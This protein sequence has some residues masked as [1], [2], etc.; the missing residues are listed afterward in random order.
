MAEHENLKSESNG[1]GGTREGSG[2]RKGGM[3]EATKERLAIKAEFQHRVALNADRLFNSQFNL[4]TGEQYL[5]CRN[6]I[7]EGTKQRTVVEVVTDPEIIKQY[8]NGELNNTDDKEWYFIS[9]KPA[10]G[11]AIDSL[12]DR[13]FGKADARLDMTTNGND[14]GTLSAEQAEQ[15]IRARA[16]RTNT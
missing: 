4:A 1:W 8:I 15:L 16:R 6:T 2:R 3:N 7:G 11:M 9:T 10:N 13:S 14:I 12:L 5:M